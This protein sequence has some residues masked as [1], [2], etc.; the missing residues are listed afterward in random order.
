MW[1]M[2]MRVSEPSPRALRLRQRMDRLGLADREL[3]RLSGVNRGT[4]HKA[5]RGESRSSTYGR[6]ERV[7]DQLERDANDGDL[8]PDHEEYVATLELVD[9][10]RVTFTGMTPEE[11]ARAAKVFLEQDRGS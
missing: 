10:T 6:L 11:A 7:L 5:L 2:A 9:G 4:I 1:G 3:S 8:L